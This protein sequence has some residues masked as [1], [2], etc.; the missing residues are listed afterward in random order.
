MNPSPT[1]SDGT[2]SLLNQ[3]SNNLISVSDTEVAILT[4]KLTTVVLPVFYII[5]F[6]VGLPTNAMA[7]CVFIFRTKK[8]HPTAIYMANLAVS[9][10]LFVIWIP[11]KISYHFNENNWVH[12]EDLCKVLA[13]FFY[14]NIYCSVL[15]I[16]CISVQR[17]F[18]VIYPMSDYNKNSKI[19]FAVSVTVWVVMCLVT[20]PLFLYD[21][22]VEIINPRITT[23][24]DVTKPQH[25]KIAS[26]FFMSMAIFTFTIPTVISIIAYVLILHGLKNST[27]D[28]SV[29]QKRQKT[30][31]LIIVVLVMFLLCF[32]PSNIMLL[33]MYGLLLNGQENTAYGIYISTLFLASLNCCVDPFVYYF[34]SEEF[35]D[36][37][38]NILICRS[39]RTAERMRVSFTAL[40]MTQRSKRNTS[41][42]NNK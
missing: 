33:V 39:V 7:I 15:F 38:R 30:V 11:L 18:A 1:N 22:T 29:R 40:K 17:Y 37:V 20:I 27:F 35:R 12:G 14:G 25:I 16:T 2:Q 9:D 5:V 31:Y 3:S 42:S 13:A 19:A 4:S 26:G 24:H 8:K 6:A 32:A 34:I 28:E 10:L 41:R 36:H 23:C 21:Q